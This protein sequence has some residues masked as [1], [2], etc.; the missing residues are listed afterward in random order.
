MLVCKQRTFQPLPLDLFVLLSFSLL[1]ETSACT[2]ILRWA[3]RHE[4]PIFSG[5]RHLWINHSPPHQHLSH[6]FDFRG[7]GESTLQGH[8]PSFSFSLADSTEGTAGTLQEKGAL[9][10]GFPVLAPVACSCW[11]HLA[12]PVMY[13]FQRGFGRPVVLTLH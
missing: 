8:F 9:F 7:I 3:L 13:P 11:Q 6:Q 10:C 12:H 1:I 4:S 2:E 5:G